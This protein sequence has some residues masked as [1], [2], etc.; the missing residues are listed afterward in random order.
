M[1]IYTDITD[2]IQESRNLAALLWSLLG[3]FFGLLLCI[4]ALR[5]LISNEQ[6]A[7]H[8]A[9][10]LTEAQRLVI[11]I[12]PDQ[13]EADNNRK[14]VHLSGEVTVDDILRDTLF[15][16]EIVN[17]IKL[18]RLVEMYQ[19]E[20]Q[21]YMDEYGTLDAR[22]RK[23]W[24]EQLIDSNQ[25]E[26]PKGHRNPRS[27]PIETKAVIAKHV[28]LGDFTLSASLIKQ[29]NH[30]QRLPMKEYSFWQV[31]ENL[32][33]QL[34]DKELHLNNGNYYIGKNPIRP[35]IGDLRIRFE[36]VHV[37]PEP[38]NT[39]TISVIAKQVGSRLVPYQSQ[40][41]EEIELFEYGLVSA[42][43]MLRYEKISQFFS[44]SRLRFL[45]FLMMFLGLYAIFSVSWVL[46]G[47]IPFLGKSTE[48]RGWLT[49]F[50]SATMIS[51]ITIAIIWIGYSP[52]T[53]KILLV[54]ALVLLFLLKFARKPPKAPT[55][56]P[57]A[58][59]P[60]KNTAD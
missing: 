56:I 58:L 16:I 35:K 17:V 21:Q 55:L 42:E 34:Q 44:D 20:E 11:P 9:K 23:K 5:T 36:I 45:G 40:T 54:I 8:H 10:T 19:W 57:E 6:Q 14:L 60:Q 22:Y 38:G 7:V 51:L 1:S 27:M 18:R 31:E 3:L 48:L 43:Q 29:M 46:D 30:Y 41:G 2:N 28:K 59:V 4:N 24:S 53:G 33:A 15:D 12:V 49:S 52:M 32:R 25:F 39:L 37:Q 50:I 47:S 26:L 13:A